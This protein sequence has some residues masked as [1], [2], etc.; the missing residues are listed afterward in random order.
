MGTAHNDIASAGAAFVIKPCQSC[1]FVFMLVND[2]FCVTDKKLSSV[3]S[4]VS[5]RVL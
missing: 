3:Y 4:D 5:V 2:G 1:V